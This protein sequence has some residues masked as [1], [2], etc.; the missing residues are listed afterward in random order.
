V[1]PRI[2]IVVAVIKWVAFAA[3]GLLALAI[4]L[5][6]GGVRSPF[7]PTEITHQEPYSDFIGREYRVTSD[8]SAYAW[9]DFPDKAKILSISLMPP[10]GIRNRFVSYVIPLQHGQRIRLV[11]ASREFPSFAKYYVVSVPGAGLPEGIRITVSVNSDGIP[12]P[13]VYAP[14]DR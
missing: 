14:I 2:R 13:R 11:S 3:F 5:T 8:V 7:P 4:V 9:N 1:H 12:D 6:V 10:P